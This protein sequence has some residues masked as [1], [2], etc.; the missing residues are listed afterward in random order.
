MNTYLFTWNPKKWDWS[1]QQSLIDLLPHQKP[2]RKWATVSTKEIS[3]GDKFILIKIGSIP[4]NE[5][6]IIGIGTI[7]SQPFK[8]KDFLNEDRI[9]N[10]VTLEFEQLSIK[11]F[12]YLSE[13]EHQ[14]SH[15][16]QKWT[17][18][19]SGILVKEKTIFNE[20]LKKIQENNMP[21]Q[22]KRLFK[23]ENYF[24][25]IAEIID[26]ALTQQNSIHRDDIVQKLL[27]KSEINL[28]NIAKNSNKPILFIAQN[29]VDWFSAELTKQSSLVSEWQEKYIRTKIKINNREVTNYSHTLN[30]QQDEAIEEKNLTYKEGAIKQ[31][32]VNAYERNDK[33]RKACLKHHGYTC[34]CCSFNFE[35]IYGI[36]GKDYIHVHHKKALYEIKEEYVLDPI[37][38]LAP[39]CANCHAM[40]HR[41]NPP[42]TIDE[43][44]R[45]LDKSLK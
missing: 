40:I 18:E 43:I 26:I 34:Q 10:F 27:N 29:M 4:K 21:I 25:I 12:I 32:T 5:K 31:I 35:K 16:A 13:L 7:I 44:R 38:D 28:E 17:P 45:L 24:P 20:I 9:R 2:T 37:I 41:K 30:I 23:K 19:G 8:D 33:A 11:P 42:Y 14:Y 1:D 15:L 22:K 3:I 6:G 39:V 36:L